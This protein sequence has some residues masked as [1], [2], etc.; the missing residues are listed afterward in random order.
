MKDK[1]NV[2]KGLP[3]QDLHQRPGLTSVHSVKLPSVGMNIFSDM[4]D[5]VRIHHH[6]QLPSAP[7]VNSTQ[8]L[9]R[10]NINAP[11]ARP[12]RESKHLIGISYIHYS[13][14]YR[15]APGTD[16]QCIAM[17]SFAICAA[18]RKG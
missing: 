11:V 8:I 5:A 1:D 12:L 3:S 2:R 6:D 10:R 14:L 16:D 13:P 15:T 9:E 4:S 7:S 17:F 18:V